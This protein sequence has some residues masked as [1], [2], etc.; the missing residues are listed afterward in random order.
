MYTTLAG[1]ILII[2]SL[3]LLI[4]IYFIARDAF[5]E[6]LLTLQ[7]IGLAGIPNPNFF[8]WIW[9][10]FIL[11]TCIGFYL[12][13]DEH[14]VGFRWV[15][16]LLLTLLTAFFLFG[17]EG[18]FFWPFALITLF[19]LILLL[20]ESIFTFGIVFRSRIGA[21][22]LGFYFFWCIYAMYIVL[23]TLILFINN[24]TIIWR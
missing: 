18:F 1:I 4:L 23:S 10:L 11:T 7:R 13:S 5:N 14:L 17:T 22:L 24:A 21:A 2:A 6:R 15:A 8:K 3:I 16:L 20:G 12:L 19:C 9:P